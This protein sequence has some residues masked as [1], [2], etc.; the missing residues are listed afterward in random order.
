MIRY[1]MYLASAWYV[2]RVQAM[3]KMIMRRT[4]RR[5]MRRRTRREKRRMERKKMENG[6]WKASPQHPVDKIKLSLFVWQ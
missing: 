5:R 4:R 3:L 1:L 2:I 6:S